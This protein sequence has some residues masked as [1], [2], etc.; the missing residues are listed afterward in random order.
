MKRR[1][2]KVNIQVN[3]RKITKVIIDPHYQDKHSAVITDELI[4]ELVDL[5][6]KGTFP[7]QDSDLNFEYFVTD[8]LKL[9]NKKYKLVW[10]LEKNKLYI[11]IVNAYRRK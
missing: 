5:L 6:H 7:V 2:Y 11:G 1:E 9:R 4:L 3:S 10:L 8:G